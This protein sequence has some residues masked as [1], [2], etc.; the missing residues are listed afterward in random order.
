[1]EYMKKAADAYKTVQVD[2]AILGA[3]PHELIEKLLARAIESTEEAKGYML[4]KDINAKGQMIKLAVA[5]ISD[6]LRG[7]LNMKEG[8][9][10]AENLDVLYEYMSRQ[11]MKAHAE[12]DTAALDEVIALLKDIKSGWDGIKPQQSQTVKAEVQPQL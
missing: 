5:I 4:A 3:S 1:M 12:N 11:L 6:G 7:S 9:E 8:G 2:A 10:I